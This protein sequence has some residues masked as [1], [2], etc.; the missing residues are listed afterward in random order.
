MTT[1]SGFHGT[2]PVSFADEGHIVLAPSAAMQKTAEFASFF[3][4]R[5]EN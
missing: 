2:P 4:K 5:N 1:T 3:A